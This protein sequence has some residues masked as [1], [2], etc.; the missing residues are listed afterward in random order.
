V[1]L[2]V[3]GVHRGTVHALNYARSLSSDITAV[4]ISVAPE[5]EAKVRSK[6]ERWGDGVRLVV[7]R[8]PYRALIEPLIGYVREVARRRQPGEMLTVVLP[9]F[10]PER[11]WHNLLHM[12]TGVFLR[13]GLLG[14]RNVV[15]TEV[16]YHIEGD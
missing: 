7:V 3:S 13:I 16:P 10:V 12:N 14:L 2:P 6:W 8:S 11:G 9:E 4:H 15:I 5:D 1:I